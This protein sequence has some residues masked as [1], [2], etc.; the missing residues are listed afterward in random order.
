MASPYDNIND[1]P[2]MLKCMM[3]I[4]SKQITDITKKKQREYNTEARLMMLL[5]HVCCL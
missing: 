5:E 3:L 2:L 1:D 4:S